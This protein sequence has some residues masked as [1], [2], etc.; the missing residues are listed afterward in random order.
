MLCL[1]W[2]THKGW[3]RVGSFCTFVLCF[4]WLDLPLES[5]GLNRYISSKSPSPRRKRGR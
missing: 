4:R 2:G 3:G 5:P 1:N